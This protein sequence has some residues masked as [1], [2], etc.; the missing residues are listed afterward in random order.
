[1]CIVGKYVG[2]SVAAKQITPKLSVLKQETCII[3]DSSYESG[4]QSTE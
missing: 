1:M 2:L 3:S 4:I